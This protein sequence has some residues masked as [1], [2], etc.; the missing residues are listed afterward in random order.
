M[1]NK[2][3][4]LINKGEKSY[5]FAEVMSMFW[6]SHYNIDNSFIYQNIANLPNRPFDSVGDQLFEVPFKKAFTMDQNVSLNDLYI[7]SKKYITAEFGENIEN[8]NQFDFKNEI[9]REMVKEHQEKVRL[10]NLI[11]KQDYYQLSWVSAFSHTFKSLFPLK[12][13]VLSRQKI[14]P[15][16]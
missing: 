3:R 15:Q 10:G 5:T 13:I 11:E 2:I 4:E 7:T 16:V 12:Q 1:L 14:R 6:K 8:Q 9:Y